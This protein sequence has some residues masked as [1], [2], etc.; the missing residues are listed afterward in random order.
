MLVHL[1]RCEHMRWM[2]EKAMDGWR[3]SGSS[4][5]LTRDN[6]KLKHHLLV[7]YDSL[8]SPEKDKD[9]NAFLWALDIPDEK[10]N[11]VNLSEESKRMVKFAKEI[12]K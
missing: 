9:Y 7:P 8:E 5:K 3:W 2:A 6:D 11:C 1:S 4:D 12:K 10:L